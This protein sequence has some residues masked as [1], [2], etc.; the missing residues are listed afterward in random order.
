MHEPTGLY[1]LFDFLRRAGVPLGAG[2]YLL[3]VDTLRAGRGLEDIEEFKFVCRLMW[4]KSADDLPVFDAAFDRL[5][6][7]TLRPPVRVEAAEQKSPP[8]EYPLLE[9]GKKLESSGSAGVGTID[10]EPISE[11]SVTE[12]TGLEEGHAP[13]ISD[14]DDERPQHVQHGVYQFIARP[15]ISRRE[16]SSIWRHLR[17]MKREGP[18]VELDVAS[19]TDRVGR[20]GFFSGPVL[21]PRRQNRIRLLVLVD[22]SKFMAPFGPL[23]DTLIE[24]MQRSGLAG[25]V[26]VRYFDGVPDRELASSPNLTGR[27]PIDEVFSRVARGR[28]VLIMGDA[29]AASGVYRQRA[30]HDTVACLRRLREYTYLYVWLNPFP[31][32]RWTGSTAEALAR[33]VAMFPMDRDGLVDAVNILRGHPVPPGIH[34]DD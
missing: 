11:S 14:P 21:R 32:E 27:Q 6:A 33:R 12:E 29:G 13:V 3:A 30:E 24:G 22:R 25:P 26:Q 5:M 4:T 19:T 28:A 15:P 1:T 34:L 9:D 7:P 23:I 8:S 2:D 16:V 31:Q 18:L 20:T 10:D 17:A